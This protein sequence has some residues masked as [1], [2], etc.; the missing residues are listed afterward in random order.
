METNNHFN[1]TGLSSAPAAS[2]PKPTPA[3]GDSPFTHSSPLSFPPQGKSLNGGMN[4][5]GFSTVSHPGTSGTF[6]PGSAPAGAQPLRAYDCLWDYAPYAPA[7]GLKDGGPPALGQFPLNGVAGG[8]RPASPGHG[9]NLRAAGQEF[10]GNGTAGPMGLNFDSQELYDSFHDQSFELM[11]NGPDGFYAAGQ[12]SPILSSD[13]QPFPLAPDEPDPGQGDAAGAAKEMPTTTTSTTTI[14]ENGGGLVGS[15]ELEEAQ[16]DLKICSYNGA[17]AAGAGS[18]GPEGTVLAPRDSG[19]LGD[20]SPIAPRLEDTHILSE[21]PLEPF[22]S[23]ARDP[24]T[25]DLYAMDDSQLVSDKSSLEEPPDLAASPPLHA[26]P[27]SLLP[28]SPSPAPLLGGPGSPLRAVPAP[29]RP[30]PVPIP[31]PPHPAPRPR[32]DAAVPRWRREVRIKKGNH[33]WQGETWYYGPCG[34]RMKQFPEVIKYLSRNMVQDVRREHFSFSPRMPVG[35]FY[36]ERDTPEGVQ[37]VKLSPEEIPG[38]IQAITGKRGRPR[39]AEK[40]KAKEPPATKRG[41]GR[42][43]KVRMV[44]L[45]SKTDAR[46]LKRLEAQEVLSEEDKLKMS[47]IKKKMRRKAKNKQKQEAKAP[48]AKE[49]KKKSKAKEKK[50]K[51]EKGKDKAR[52]KEKKG[53]G[54]R[55]A[56]KGLLAQRRLEERQRQQLILEEMKKPTEDMCLGDHQPLP[57]FSRIPGLVLPSRAF[58]DCLTVVEFLQSYGKVLGL[59]PARDVPTLGALQEGLLGVAPGAG[60]LQDLLVRLLQAA[61]CDPGLP[62]YCQSLKI[63]GEKVSEISLNRDTVSEVLRCFLTAHGAGA[64]LCEGLRTKPFQALPPERK[65]AILVFL[66]NEL[67]SSAL[68]ISEIDKTLENMSNYRKNKWIIEGRLRR[69]KVALAKRTGRPESEITGLEDGRR[70]RS[71]RLTEDT[72]LEMEEEEETRGR[73]SRREEEVDT[74]TSSVPE[75]ERQIEKLAKRQM[76]FRKKLLHSSQTLRAASLGQDRFRRRYWVLPHL[77]GIFVEGAEAAEAVAQEPP[78]EKVSPHVSLV[79]EEPAAVPVA[80]RTSC[81]AS[82]SRA[83]GRPRKSKE[84]LAQHCGPCP[85]PVN[86]V[87]E[88]PEPLGQSQHD[89]SQSAFLSWLSQTQSS[90]LKDSVLTPASSP[91]KGDTGLPPPEA[92]SD[93]ME[94][95]EEEEEEERAPEAVAKRGPWFNLLPRTPCD[96]RAPLATSSA[97]PSPR[98]PAAPR[99][100]SRGE[101]PKGPA[102]QLN[103]LPADDPTA[104]LLASTPV[105]AGPRAHGACP[106][107]QGSLEKLQDVPGQP[108]RRGR[109]PTKF[110]K[111]MEQKY[112]TQLTE[113]PVPSEMQSGWWWLRDPE[114]LEAVAR[115]LHPRGIREKALH[116]HLTKHKE[117]LREVCLRNTTDPIFHPRPESAAAAVSQEALAQWSVP[118]RAYET[119]LG[120]LQWVEELEQRVLMADLQIRGWTCPSPDSTRD[121]LRYCEHKVEP[122]EDITV[123]SRRD[124]DGLP[125]RR[126]LTNPLD[127]AVLRL[128][129]L[130]QNLE[131]RYLKEP[132]WP[133]HEV[134]VE[135]AVLS[136]PEEPSLGPTEISYEITPRVRTWRQTLER[137]RSAAQVSL[138]IFQLEKSIAWEK[139]VNRVTCLVCRRGDDDEHLLLCDGCDR[140][141]HLY[142]HRPRMTEVPEGDWFCSVCVARAGQ[143]RDP[144][145]PRRGKKR[146]R[147][148]AVAG[149]PGEEEPSPRR[150]AAPRRREGLPVS[151]RYPGEALAPARRRSS[152]LR[153]QPSDLTFCEIILMEMES[154]EDAWPFLEPVNPRLV[155]GYRKIIKNPMDFATMRTRLLRGGYSSSAE[156]AADALLV[157]DNCQTFNE[158]DS[159]V[160]RAGHAMR[161]FF[162][163]RWEEF[164]QGKHAP[165]P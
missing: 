111:Q 52:P 17:A 133:L 75:L 64:E 94:E 6:S 99:S 144:V 16:P 50:G 4:V 132:L 19:C 100:Q 84:E 61:L 154:H 164:Y 139:S 121:D 163:S 80:S 162:Q 86:G 56:D 20:A 51:P 48:R 28:A 118:D 38:R 108:K 137:C 59:E 77:G 44:D 141:C 37:W 106:R 7:G 102:R 92:P 83:R 57:A 22:E 114:E 150:R 107:S 96:D 55:K 31:P 134:V 45:L 161:R 88:E 120:V 128:A 85:A 95:E 23:L 73:K 112:L 110:F 53:K 8:S 147:G 65:A 72:G 10:W 29:F 157:F 143:Y 21:D 142:C 130:E 67:N 156:F 15:Q 126:E 155:P 76:F 58:S 71:S 124:R 24:G 74:S 165:N 109:P 105:H 39:N 36:E 66:V 32:A 152:A 54:A 160:G 81:P 119:D 104:P 140:G 68:I 101:P 40:A 82:A 87:L 35:D 125:L 159:A 117:F 116:K 41:R 149:S 60:Q 30:D 49:V 25:G 63:L 47:K 9:T 5:N 62:P 11:Q 127:L 129:A 79:K 18:L 135:K 1:F 122:L 26:G 12:S 42:P 69:L 145:S 153:G 97:E 113:Q 103:G 138:C 34:K 148:R 123:R 3:S 131:R 89:L 46:L 27:F 98:A 136:G 13:A 78:E 93:P 70:R 158:D 14:A 33:R 91:G 151:P 43:P 146:K 115:A 90:L 2:G